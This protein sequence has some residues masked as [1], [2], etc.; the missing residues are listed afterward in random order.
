MW[1][2]ECDA[3]T[4]PLSRINLNHISE[5]LLCTSWNIGG[6]M[7]LPHL[8]LLQQLT[9]IVVIKW[10]STLKTEQKIHSTVLHHH[11]IQLTTSNA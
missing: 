1:S 5:K 4:E 10:K 11:S 2:Y 6:N 3:Y 8:N 7:K 9:K